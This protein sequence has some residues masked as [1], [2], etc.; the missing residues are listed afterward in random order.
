MTCPHPLYVFSLIRSYTIYDLIKERRQGDPF[1][2]HG[3]AIMHPKDGDGGGGY[4]NI[5]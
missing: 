4:D 2:P 1:C 5:K 3:S